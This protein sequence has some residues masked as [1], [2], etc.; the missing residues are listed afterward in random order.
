[1]QLQQSSA[2]PLVTLSCLF[3]QDA[4]SAFLYG[5]RIVRFRST[6]NIIIANMDACTSSS[7]VA[8]T[9]SG[10]FIPCDSPPGTHSFLLSLASPSDV[11][12]RIAEL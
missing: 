3:R 9:I 7:H 6:L 12:S 11:G 2:L 4:S 1:M 10:Y 8:R 5:L